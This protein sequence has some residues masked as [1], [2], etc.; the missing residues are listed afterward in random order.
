MITQDVA[1]L[2][3][4]KAGHAVLANTSYTFLLRQKP[5]VINN[6]S[7][8]FNLS[9][10]EKEYLMTAKQ[11]SGILIL[12]NEHQ[13]ITVIASEAEHK[14]ITTNPEEMSKQ[15]EQEE[16]KPTG[17]I[18]EDEKANI[19]L[20]KLVYEAKGLTI[21]QTNVLNN[22]GY[23]IKK[24]HG[25]SSGPHTY[26]VKQRHPESTEHTLLV[27]LIIEEIKKYTTEIQT[28]QTKKPDIIFTNKVGQEIALEIETG[29]WSE[30]HKE[31]LEEKFIQIKKEYGDRCYIILTNTHKFFSYK[32]Y[33]LKIIGRNQIEEFMRLQFSGQK[34]SDIGKTFNFIDY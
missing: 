9:Q 17:I 25:L 30:I 14:L 18:K 33:D 26:F 3:D 29:K 11:G 4:S 16:P 31:R 8:T 23:I 34:N 32:K 10:A 24:G 21:L 7:K 19:D 15:T 28:Y 27:G 2:V 22:H 12:E 13:E 1:D 20:S 5:A 6:V